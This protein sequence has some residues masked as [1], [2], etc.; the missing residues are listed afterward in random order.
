M[1]EAVRAALAASADPVRAPAMQ[2]YMKSAMP[3]LGVPSPALKRAMSALAKQH[4]PANAEAWHDTVLALFREATYRE[5]RYAALNLAART[6][7][8]YDPATL[9]LFEELVVAGAWWDIVDE[10]AHRIGDVLDRHRVEVTP[11]LR[12]WA[13]DPVLWKR[14][15]AII[16]Q[17]GHRKRTDLDLLREA[18]QAN[19]EDRDFFIRKAIGWAL[20]EYAKHDMPWVV[21]YV[22]GLG[23]RL[24]PLSRREAL[25]H[26][27]AE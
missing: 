5:E 10:C 7:Y 18:I 23:A 24:S 17:L 6:P 12:A 4:P 1:I 11:T 22:E 27:P 25:K 20:R 9:P 13:R 21:A 2:A 19:L 14:R 8:R 16:C 26:A 15:V 3:F